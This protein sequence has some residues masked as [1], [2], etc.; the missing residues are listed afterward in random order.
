MRTVDLLRAVRD[1]SPVGDADLRHFVMGITQG[2]VPD[3]QA[4]A[5]LMAVYMRG[6]PDPSTAALTLAMRDSGRVLDLRDIPGIKV[7]KHSTGGVGDKI[8]LPLAPL[9]AACGV[10]VPMIS[11][12]GLGHTGGTLDKLESIPGFRTDFDVPTFHRIIHK[13]GTCL[14]GQTSDI[15]PADKKL[16][17][18]RDVTATV[19][20]VPL[21]TAS[22]LA[23]KLAEGIDA[24]VLDVKVGRGA[25]MRDLA[26]A[27]RLALSLVRVGTEAGLKVRAVLT[28][29]E[30]PLGRTI[31][32]A[33]EVRES[34]D[35]LKAQGPSDTT[36]LTLELAAHMLLLGGARAAIGEARALAQQKLASGEALQKF[37][38]LIEAHGGDPRVV[39]D[40]NR[41]PTAQHVTPV[42]SMLGGVITH[43]D[44]F[45]M[46]MFAMRLGAGRTQAAD[47]IDPAVGIELKHTVGDAI[48]AGDAWCLI[49]HNLP[50]IEPLDALQQAFVVGAAAPPAAPLVLAVEDGL[51]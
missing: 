5:F 15:A 4:T 19:E 43:M 22:I 37:A 50:L 38:Q 14:I 21:I 48:Q 45:A 25:F 2:T 29:M 18:L 51:G 13:V 11:G 35:I 32:N 36:A 27:Q 7:D 33:L 46:G 16:Y 40:P 39:D 10:P 3:Y 47:R 44:S 30:A 23:K 20:S 1:G 6:L 31:G 17:A 8:S 12:R 28:R 24:L 26:E 41:L 9:V 42:R 34:I 49:H